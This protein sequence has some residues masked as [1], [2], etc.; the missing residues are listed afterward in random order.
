MPS[1]V[2]KMTISAKIRFGELEHKYE[3][4]LLDR[5]WFQLPLKEVEDG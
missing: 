5:H 3:E 2:Y 4:R 1:K